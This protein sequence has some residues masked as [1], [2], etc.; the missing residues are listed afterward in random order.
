LFATAA[1]RSQSSELPRFDRVLLLEPT[2][3]T[4]ANVNIGDVNA[5]G[6]LDL[7]L[8]KGRHWP[9]ADRVLLGNGRGGFESAYDLAPTAD[10]SYSGSL[11][12]LDLDGD[13]D[14]VISNDR[15]DPKR[16]Y[17]N[18]GKGRFREAG[19]YGRPEWSTRNA[20]VAD[21][22]GDKLPDI[23]VANRTP[24]GRGANYVCLNRG[25]ARFENDCVAFSHESATTITPADVNH[26][27]RTDLVVPHR[28]GGQSHIYINTS[29]SGALAFVPVPFGPPDAAIRMSA[30]ADLDRDGRIDLVAID[31]K[32][33]PFA[34]FGLGENRFSAPV[35]IGARGRTPYALEAADLNGDGRTD[36]IVG[37]IEAPST[38]FFNDGSGR[39]FTPV[40]FGDGRGTPYGFD[41]ADLDGDGHADIAAARSDAPNAVYFATLR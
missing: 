10:R 34:F 20:A 9:L 24:T 25:R 14:I 40:D 15:P 17:V 35:P 11:V 4:S 3:E 22:D 19:T 23:I 1:P 7:V 28:D 37:N 36:I 27:G 8:A 21:L 6:H 39:A 32:H 26:D 13:L 12:D 16:I 30:A 2:S 41:V 29:T 18:D 31:Q 33:G 5:D 38:V